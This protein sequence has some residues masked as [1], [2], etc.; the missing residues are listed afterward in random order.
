MT[1]RHATVMIPFCI[2][3]KN[4]INWVVTR[5]DWIQFWITLGLYLMIVS[6]EV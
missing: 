5:I 1:N 2:Y 4:K 3:I 6:F